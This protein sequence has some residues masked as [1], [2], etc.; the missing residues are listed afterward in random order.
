MPIARAHRETIGVAH[1]RNL[2]DRD[3]QIEVGDEPPDDGELLRILFAEIGAVRLHHLKQLQHHGCDAAEV[4]WTEFPAE[5]VGQAADVDAALERLRIDLNRRRREHDIDAKVAAQ[6]H[7]GVNRPRIARQI[8]LIVELQR[9][10]E[11]RNDDHAA[12]AARLSD[13]RGMSGMQGA[14]GGHERPSSR[15]FASRAP[16]RQAFA[17]RIDRVNQFQRHG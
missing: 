6:C 15:A 9:I 10:D 1:R 13:Q 12:V 7:V 17:Q 3:R 14:H 8:V 5:M 11:D 16:A 2:D 4:P